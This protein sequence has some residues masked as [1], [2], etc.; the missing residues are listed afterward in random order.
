MCIRVMLDHREN[1]AKQVTRGHLVK[2]ESGEK[3]VI[4]EGEDL[5]VIEENLELL[6]VRVKWEK[7]VKLVNEEYKDQLD[8]KANRYHLLFELL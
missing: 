5:K 7:R 1:L 2:L 4:E 3:R 6:G 8:L